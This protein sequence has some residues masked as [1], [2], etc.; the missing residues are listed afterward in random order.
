[1]KKKGREKGGEGWRGMER[2]GE[3]LSDCGEEMH[4][5]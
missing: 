1:L 2:D 3:G 5:E 4:S